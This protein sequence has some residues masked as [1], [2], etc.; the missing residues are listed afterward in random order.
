MSVNDTNKTKGGDNEALVV[1]GPL[2]LEP[3]AGAYLY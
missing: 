2:G 1:E 3:G